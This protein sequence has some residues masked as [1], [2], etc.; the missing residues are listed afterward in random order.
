MNRRGVRKRRWAAKRWENLRAKR[1][2]EEEEEQQEGNQGE[3]EIEEEEEAREELEQDDDRGDQGSSREL[4]GN[5][6]ERNIEDRCCW[7]LKWE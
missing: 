2:E 1:E 5:S 3:G 4:R 7:V 6:A